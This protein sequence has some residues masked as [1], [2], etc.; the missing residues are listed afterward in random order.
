MFPGC[1]T[2]M[3]CIQDMPTMQ[4]NCSR[5]QRKLQRRDATFKIKN[6]NY[7]LILQSLLGYIVYTG[8]LVFTTIKYDTDSVMKGFPWNIP[9]APTGLHVLNVTLIKHS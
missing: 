1:N 3:C 5:K 4:N 8:I 9:G 6:P 2:L 7:T